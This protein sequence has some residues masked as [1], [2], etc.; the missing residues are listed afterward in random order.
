MTVNETIKRLHELS[1][2]RYGSSDLKYPT[3]IKRKDC[4]CDKFVLK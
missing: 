2:L 4:V 1:E 3:N